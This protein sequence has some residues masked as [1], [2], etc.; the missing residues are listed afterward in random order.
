MKWFKT[1]EKHNRTKELKGKLIL[2]IPLKK[3]KIN[4]TYPRLNHGRFRALLF[5]PY[6][7]WLMRSSGY[8]AFLFSSN[9]RELHRKITVLQIINN[10]KQCL[11]SRPKPWKIPMEEL[12]LSK[13]NS[14]EC[15]FTK[16]LTNSYLFQ[17]DS[18]LPFMNTCC[19]KYLSMDAY[20]FGWSL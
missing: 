14:T 10:K 9:H 16:T 12:I 17:K 20:T 18:V 3:M 7:D 4:S 15:N 11:K 13:D 6:G 1:N 2:S 8:I 19:N 5:Q